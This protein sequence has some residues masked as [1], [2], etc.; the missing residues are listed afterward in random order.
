MAYL[1]LTEAATKY[2][3]VVQST[4]ATIQNSAPH[5]LLERLG[6]PP[7][8]KKQ[9]GK[10]QIILEELHY[11]IEGHTYT[12]FCVR[13]VLSA[14]SKD[15][16]TLCKKPEEWFRDNALTQGQVQQIETWLIEE[17]EKERKRNELPD[18]PEHLKQWLNLSFT[19]ESVSIY[20]TEDWSNSII[21]KAVSYTHLRAHE[22]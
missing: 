9:A 6:K 4:L 11:Q 13:T 10:E 18:L 16:Q 20:E 5:Q 12:V 7:I 22:T 15:Y 8:F 17:I 21:K 19:L 2:S 14:G 3:P 1:F